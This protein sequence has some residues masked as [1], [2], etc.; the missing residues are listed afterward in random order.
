MTPLKSDRLTGPPVPPRRDDIRVRGR[1]RLLC[2]S[3]IFRDVARAAMYLFL[4]AAI[5]LGA[6][7]EPA[8]AQTTAIYTVT[9][10]GNWNTTSTPGGVVGS[11]H[12]TTLIGAVHDSDVTFWAA[13]G[14]A[15]AGVEGVAE[16]GAT[17][18]FKSEITAAGA[19]VKSTVQASG[20][21]ATGTR[22][23]EVTFSRTHPLLTLLSMIG[24]S[25]DWFV[26]VSGLSLLDAS[27][28]WRSSY[29]RDLFP[30]DAGTEDGEEFSLSNDPTSPQGTITSLKGQGKFSNT[31]MARLTFTLNQS[32]NAPEFLS[33]SMTRSIAETVGAA[34]VQSAGNVDAPITATDMDMD[35]L[36][37]TLEGADKDEFTIDS[38]GQIKTRVGES[39]DRETKANYSVIVKADDGNG[40]TDTITVTIDL[41]NV[42]ERP[43]APAAPSVFSGSTTS[44]NVMWSA[45]SNT[46]RPPITSYDLQYRQGMTGSWTDGPQGV[47][48]MS[49]T[50]MN[51]MEDTE[52]QVQIL[53]SNSDG[54]G[55]WSQP[56]T[57][58]TNARGNTPP[59]FTEGMTV[60]R[61]FTET[62]GGATVGIAGNVGA[63]VTATDADNDTLAYSLEGM[64]A[65]KFTV[66]SNGQIKTKVGE[67]YDRE[68]RASYSVMVKADDRNGGTDTI[69]VMVNVDNE[70]ELPLVLAAPSVSLAGT[71]SVN[72]T[73]N[74]PSNTGRPPITSYDLQ[75][76]QGTS[77]G[78]TD[79]SQGDISGTSAT[80]AVSD[81]NAEYQARVL[82]T[83]SDGDSPWSE[84]GSSANVGPVRPP[85]PPPPP[86]TEAEEVDTDD[87]LREFVENAAERITASQTFGETLSLLE[88]FRDEGEWN[89]GS[90]YL[91]LLT[92][93]G[94]VYFHADDREVE[95]LGWSGVLFCERGGSVL[96]REEGCFIEYDGERSGYAH[97]LSASHVPL[98]HGEEEFVLLG[99]FDETP[100]GEPFTG[101][102]GRLSTEAGDVDT[103]EELREFV[104]DAGRTLM[105]AIVNSEIDPAQLRGILRR[106][107]P[108]RE[109]DVYIYIMDETGK[110][111][112]DGADR[113]REQKDESAKRYV[114]DLIAEAGEGIVEYR[115]GGMLRRGYA[116]RVEAP[117]DENEGASRVYI[118]GSGYRAM[119]Q[120]RE[121]GQ[122]GGSD[123]GGGGCA[124][125]GSGSGGA[126]G[127]FFAALTL[128]LAV[129]LKRQRHSA[130]GKAH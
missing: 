23:F 111:M 86:P 59:E 74:A 3:R 18:T 98:A 106:E 54:D 80:I 37:Y 34:T 30:Y 31:R 82:A 36:T 123:S 8:R 28:A 62:V 68:T 7:P 130:E 124:V 83:N 126:F 92:E 87:E 44:V 17:G 72:V 104:G 64:D 79:V 47:T 6:Q 88:Q 118:V 45:P 73:W 56:G 48:G 69:A 101:E 38:N 33:T 99:G 76:R 95:D 20:T 50:I 116:V 9:F 71:T 49:S 40:G 53:A 109:G 65:G 94:G 22:T 108:W 125:G 81:A 89:D 42:S 102:I 35:M 41:D 5:V 60:T 93:R 63:V 103:D 77:E 24:P 78:W 115:E 129:F 127:L 32:N 21:A 46:G 96:G 113:S 70:T 112:F 90:M 107:G 52:Y 67:S 43:L 29:T 91:V 97:P 61:N 105:G 39:Y 1:T 25:P 12:F 85:P 121:E 75:Y 100:D 117:L 128:L 57:G 11:A 55:L 16:L 122:P 13:G 14:T 15:T 119:E 2:F 19:A 27:N 26:G 10:K 110:V 58:R 66:D 120:P 4:L 51:L 114:K 84:P